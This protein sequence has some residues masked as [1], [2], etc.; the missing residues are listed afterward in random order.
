MAEEGEVGQAR[1]PGPTGQGMGS[2]CP[3]HL[4]FFGGFRRAHLSPAAREDEEP[5]WGAAF[6]GPT[7]PRR[8]VSSGVG[9][10]G[11]AKGQRLPRKRG[12][13]YQGEIEGLGH[14]NQV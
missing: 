7:S 8:L 4:Q 9:R 5:S 12:E 1:P 11:S 10:G 14:S 2:A 3:N 6:F 13:P